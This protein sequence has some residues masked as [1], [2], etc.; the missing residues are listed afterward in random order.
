[1]T[2]SVQ[3]ELLAVD[4][5][6]PATLNAIRALQQLNDQS[7]SE[8]SESAAAV[9]EG[10]EN[11]GALADSLAR[12]FE[13]ATPEN[14][15]YALSIQ[16]IDQ[17]FKL[18]EISAS[19]A[20]KA[21]RGI[22][23]EINSTKGVTDALSGA[24]QK[25][26][27]VSLSALAG[28]TGIAVAAMAVVSAMKKSIDET[29]KYTL[30]VD[31]MAR[32]TGSSVEDSSR[33]LQV[34][35]S[36]QMSQSQFTAALMRASKQGIDVSIDGLKVLADKYVALQ[37]GLQ[38]TEFLLNT[39][40]ETGY[41]VGELLEGGSSG[42]DKYVQAVDKSLVVTNKAVQQ[43]KDYI[44]TQEDLKDVQ[45]SLNYSVGRVAMEGYRQVLLGINVLINGYTKETKE[46]TTAQRGFNYVNR[47]TTDDLERGKEIIEDHKKAL[48]EETEALEDMWDAM[49]RGESVMTS[50]ELSWTKATKAQ[51]KFD[52]SLSLIG[53]TLQSWGAE[54][55][56]IGEQIW[57]GFLVGIGEIT[58]AAAEE[59]A[60]MQVLLE[61]VRK[62]A[63]AG[64][65]IP[66]I[67]QYI[68]ESFNGMQNANNPAGPSAKDWVL[69]GTKG[70]DGTESAWWSASL[71]QWYYGSKPPGYATG[72][73][74]IVPPGFSNDSFPMMVESGEHVSVTPKNQVGKGGGAAIDYD[75]LADAVARA[76]AREWQKVS[77]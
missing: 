38:R 19:D 13:S 40:G 50:F 72:G 75:R 77:R 58:P 55:G 74:F 22:S 14:L 31:D 42:L 1:M 76:T 56:P 29:V 8:I 28:P 15:R 10:F 70:G 7:L 62:M 21:M 51:D 16:E 67:V 25:L 39:F 9:G 24:F 65:S 30:A 37:P 5:V 57:R 64:V 44:K 35:D 59:F 34:I 66:I 18:G 60:R 45:E 4:K 32:A 48:E 33:L 54:L 47:I 12:K 41:R 73:S 11:I 49:D 61:N 53:S 27:G 46:A 69:K 63:A 71:G 17:Q 26:T 23:N 68:T 52:V 43:T 20:A 36:L 6:T 2:N 3:I